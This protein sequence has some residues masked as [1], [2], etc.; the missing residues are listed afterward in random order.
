[1]KCNT[2]SKMGAD[3]AQCTGYMLKVMI[4][5]TLFLLTLPTLAVAISSF[6]ISGQHWDSKC[7]SGFI[8]LQ[9]W[10]VGNGVASLVYTVGGVLLAIVLSGDK[11]AIYLVYIFVTTI[12][13]ALFKGIWN[14]IGAAVLFAS[15]EACE[16]QSPPLWKMTLATLILQWIIFFFGLMI[17]VWRWPRRR[18]EGAVQV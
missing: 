11:F 13:I 7:S 12:L 15:S 1:M 17:L 6:V 5:I 9:S 2:L 14:I 16:H 8:S 4:A 3:T 10:L 18:P